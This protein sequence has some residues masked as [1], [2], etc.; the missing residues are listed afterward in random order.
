VADVDLTDILLVGN[1]FPASETVRRKLP[2]FRVWCL[3]E[4]GAAIEAQIPIVMKCG[5]AHPAESTFA[6]DY[7]TLERMPYMVNV[8]SA[9][10]SVAKDRED[11]LRNVEAAAGGA[12]ALNSAI[13]GAVVGAQPIY[14]RY[15]PHY[16]RFFC[17]QDFDEDLWGIPQIQAAAL[18]DSRALLSLCNLG[19][20]GGGGG[21]QAFER[22]FISAC[23]GGYLSVVELF[24][25]YGAVVTPEALIAASRG[26]SLPVVELLLAAGGAEIINEEAER[27][28]DINVLICQHHVN[29]W[30]LRASGEGGWKRLL[31]MTAATP[32][33]GA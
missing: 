22:P 12:N 3:V 27:G 18:G 32:L 20:G 26:G 29:D 19:G 30:G 17:Q 16:E 31:G 4:I 25:Q 21:G 1:R 13:I 24:F 2:F 6:S 5:E 28:R 10:A 9:E 14:D 15:D 23:L 11:I 33:I 8:L 7:E